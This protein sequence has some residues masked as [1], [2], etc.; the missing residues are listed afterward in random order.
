MA[1]SDLLLQGE[2]LQELAKTR[3]DEYNV[4]RIPL[5][6]FDSYIAQGYE[7]VSRSKRKARVRKLKKQDEIFENRVWTLFYKMG[8]TS[9]NKDRHCV[10]AYDISGDHCTKQ[11]DVL[12]ADDETI[13][14]VECKSATQ[15]R[16]GNFK[17]NLESYRGILAG[18]RQ[19]LRQEFC[20]RKLAFIYATNNYDLGQADIDRIQGFNMVHFNEETINYYYQLVEHLGKSA[21]YQLLGTLFKGSRI[22]NMEMSIPAIKGTMGK[23]DYYS[24]LIEPGK[25]LKIGYVLHRNNA[26]EDMMPTYQRLIKKERLK[27]IRQFVNRGGYFPNSIIISIDEG[28]T[29]LVFEQEK[30]EF[31]PSEIARLGVLK[32]PPIYQSAYIID[33]QH[34]LY[35]Y[36][37]SQFADSNTIPV[38]AFVNLDKEEQVKMFMD[39]N[40]N[41]KAV[42]K[43]LR[44]TLEIDL[45]WD[46]E[47]E[48]LRRKAIMLKIAQVLGERKKSPLYG[49][50]IT[51]E[52]TKTDER[53]L[54]L[55]NLKIAL[56]KTTF[57]NS[58]RNGLLVHSGCFDYNDNDKTFN[59]VFGLLIDAFSFI[60]SSCQEKWDKKDQN[61]LITNNLI[62]A[63]II[64]LNDFAVLLIENGKIQKETSTE[65]DVYE[66][67]Q[68]FLQPLVSVLQELSEK[69]FSFIREKRG[70]GALAEVQKFLGYKI[71]IKEK[72]FLP[73]WLG[74]YIDSTCQENHDEAEHL[75]GDTLKKSREVVEE[76]LRQLFGEDYIDKGISDALYKKLSI[77]KAVQE[78]ENRKNGINLDLPL[79]NVASFAELR[80]IT[81]TNSNWTKAFK[82][83]FENREGLFGNDDILTSLENIYSQVKQG[84][85]IPKDTFE[86]LKTFHDL[87]IPESQEG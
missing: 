46:S 55:E 38:I 59:Y 64:L 31:N 25:L 74:E 22:S 11:I 67:L 14:L 62:G 15:F 87:I 26:N 61:S 75:L 86:S 65:Q 68:F 41:Q 69:D 47:K 81:R 63:I 30:K 21:K 12:C 80:Q 34:R 19:T 71:S 29:K 50:I 51:G 58:Y 8:F 2:E 20:D 73:Q 17:Q 10:V 54:T 37:E 78:R 48:E 3:K 18:L 44:N 9:L 5:S 40:E 79:I 36:S 42:P 57:F 32:I 84:R 28:K 85:N 49:R 4:E 13:I 24:F 39:I 70:A 16:K 56:N 52:N 27:Q 60:E 33:G 77:E 23:H 82:M 53:I 43:P 72:S 6:A 45:L 7:E 83:I 76:K 1:I 66:Q 35:G